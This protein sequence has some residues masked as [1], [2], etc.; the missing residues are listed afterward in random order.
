MIIVYALVLLLDPATNRFDSHRMQHF[1]DLR[2]ILCTMHNHRRYFVFVAHS[3]DCRNESKK[4]N[5]SK[6]DSIESMGPLHLNCFIRFNVV[7]Q[8]AEDAA[9]TN[10]SV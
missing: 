5:K 2:F 3:I 7:S 4:Q 9:Y 6:I 8:Y 10:L 1:Y